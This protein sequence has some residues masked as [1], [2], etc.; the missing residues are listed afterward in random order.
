MYQYYQIVKRISKEN[1]HINLDPLQPYDDL[2]TND[3]GL[4]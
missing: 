1:M 4:F 2:E 3:T